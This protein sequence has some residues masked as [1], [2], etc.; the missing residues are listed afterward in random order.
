MLKAAQ[1][2]VASLVLCFLL[3]T[4][5][6][7]APAGT[8]FAIESSRL[9]FTIDPATGVKTEIATVSANAGTTA[10]L[11]YDPV[12]NTV[13]LSSTNNDALYTLDLATGAATLVGSYGTDVVM[14][15]LEWDSSTG[16]LYGASSTPNSFYS[17]STATGAATLVGSIGLSSFNNLGYDAANDVMYMTN[18]SADALYTLDRATGAPSLVGSLSGSTNPNGLAYAADLGVM[19][20]A[21]N[22]TDTLYSLNLS[23]GAATAIGSTGS[24]NILGLVYVA[25][26]PEPA[27]VVLWGLGLAGLMGLSA[28][29]RAAQRAG[30]GAAVGA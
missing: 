11:A 8:L 26:V 17:I 28:R 18:S 12:G 29:R 25:V 15:G 21:D 20:L 7:G 2:C 22:S 30:A 5:Q 13:Y 10:G 14:H 1:R 24:G 3:P 16:T 19:F 6:A 23:T 4:V 9:L 27:S